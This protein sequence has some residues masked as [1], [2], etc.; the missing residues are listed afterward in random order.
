MQQKV[1]NNI[2][3]TISL[4]GF[5][6]MLSSFWNEH[7]TAELLIIG[8]ILVYFPIIILYRPIIK[9]PEIIY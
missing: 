3:I 2:A 4:V 8:V 6:V 1:K 9:E 7:L 5:Y